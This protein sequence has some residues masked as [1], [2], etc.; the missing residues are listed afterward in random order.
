MKVVFCTMYLGDAPTKPFRDS[1]EACLPA[2]EDEGWEHS[3]VFEANCPYISAARAKVLKKAYNEDPDYIVFLDYDVSWTPETMVKFLSIEGDVVSG[4]YRKKLYCPTY[5]GSLEQGPNGNPLVREDG[6]LKA[7]CVPAGFLKLSKQAVDIFAATYPE[8]LFGPKMSPELDMFNHGVVDGIWFGEDYAFSKRWNEKCGDI[9]LVPDLDIDHNSKNEVF[10]GNFHNFLINYN[11]P[12]PILSLPKVSIIIPAYNYA[13]YIG[14]AIESVLNQTYQNI[15]IIV[16]NDGST[17]NTLEVVTKYPISI[18]TQPNQG[19]SVARNRGISEST[20]EWIICLDADDKLK[21]TYIEECL[22]VPDADIIGTAMQIFGDRKSVHT[23]SE[24]PNYF[25]FIPG[26][27]IHCA[28]MFR[29][30]AWRDVGGFD[31]ELGSV[32]DDWDFWLGLAKLGY[33]FRII[34][35]PLFMYR[36]HGDSMITQANARHNELCAYMCNKH[37]ITPK[38]MF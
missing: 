5:M 28:A 37:G 1:L 8:L 15:E 6:C 17:D 18:F 20:G 4:T 30:S 35:K 26:N 31:K 34:K 36:K 11:K 27:Q 16:V 38:A 21:P 12:V 3:L 25:D 32:Y 7:H 29:K 23:F 2:I 14:E 9:W 13:Q 22:M 24:N 10:K 33:E 19:A